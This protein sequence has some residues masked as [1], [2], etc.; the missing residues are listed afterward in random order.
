MYYLEQ[1]LIEM[2]VKNVT[3]QMTAIATMRRESVL[4]FVTAHD[5]AMANTSYQA[6]KWKAK[7]DRDFQLYRSND[8]KNILNCKAP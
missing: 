1:I 8:L 7:K 6:H 3:A 5:L 4:E 2:L